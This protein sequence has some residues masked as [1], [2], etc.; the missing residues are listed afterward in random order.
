MSTQAKYNHPHSVD[1]DK[2]SLAVGNNIFVFDDRMQRWRHGTLVDQQG[3]L[4]VVKF[5]HNI[6]TPKIIVQRQ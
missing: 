4:S 1:V 6:Y 5:L 3:K 2:A